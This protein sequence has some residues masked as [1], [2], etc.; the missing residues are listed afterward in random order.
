[1]NLQC[2]VQSQ[3]FP[4]AADA[5]VIYQ[6]Q[7]EIQKP[8]YYD[9]TGVLGQSA[10]LNVVWVQAANDI[11]LPSVTNAFPGLR[12]CTFA[13]KLANASGTTVPVLGIAFTYKNASTGVRLYNMM[14]TQFLTQ[15]DLDEL[16]SDT[17]MQG[18]LRFVDSTTGTSHSLDSTFPGPIVSAFANSTDLSTVYCH[19]GNLPP[20]PGV[21][22]LDCVKTKSMTYNNSA[23]R[24]R[25]VLAIY[26]S[27]AFIGFAAAIILCGGAGIVAPPVSFAGAILCVVAASVALASALAA[28]MLD[29]ISCMNTARR[30]LTIDLRDCGITIVEM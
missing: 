3:L 21:V 17:R 4:G 18:G 16:T 25:E 20:G 22:D 15:S 13:G 14:I 7:E 29:Y 28:A 27:A 10:K 12:A 5:T 9:T 26:T 1:M 8:G 11:E 23:R 6:M 19:F 30:Q 24:C 2:T